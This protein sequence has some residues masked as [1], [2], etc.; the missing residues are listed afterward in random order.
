MELTLSSIVV[1]VVFC[2][3]FYTPSSSA[4]EDAAVGDRPLVR[5]TRATI[6]GERNSIQHRQLGDNFHR[7]VAVFKNIPFAE[8]PIGDLRYAEPVPK[9]LDGEFDATGDCLLCLQAKNPIMFDD[10]EPLNFSEDCLYL[11]V[12]VPEPKPKAAAVMVWIHGGGYHFGTKN[13]QKS[14]AMALV[15]VEDVIVVSINYRLGILGF[16]ST[17]DGAIPG[18]LGLLDQRLGLLWVK[19]NIAAFGG[20]PDRVTIFGESA[21]S[22]SVNCHLL[23]SMSAGLFSGA[24]MQSGAMSPTW[25]FKT[26]KEN[27]ELTFAFGKAM[28]CE[29][30][31]STELLTCLRGITEED[32]NALHET[33]TT[34]VFYMVAPVADGHFL[35]LDPM[36]AQEEGSFNPSNVIIGSL[37][38]EGNI[39]AVPFITGLKGYEKVPVNRTSFDT[40]ISLFTRMADPL[41]L[42][43]IKLAYLSAEQLT[44]GDPEENLIDPMAQFFG[45]QMFLCPTFSTAQQLAAAG[46]QVYTYLMTHSPAYSIWGSKYTWLEDTHGEDVPYV[47]GSA[48]LAQ[49][50]EDEDEDWMLQGRLADDEVVIARRIMKYWANFAKTGN[51]NLGTNEGD[52]EPDQQFPS[53]P[54]FTSETKTYKD[55]SRNMENLSGTTPNARECYF[56]EHLLPKLIE[57][58]AEMERL[59]SLVEEKVS[60]DSERS[61]EDPDTCPEE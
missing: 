27:A 6:R 43:L 57:N 31:S 22:S 50:G 53:W 23:S 37:G 5:T 52:Q 17:E 2:I 1:M 60:K 34:M 24:I 25:T 45:D 55:L 47:F 9:T 32:I 8:P 39:F 46:I 19:E 28:G 29:T 58:A 18:N 54:T 61:C 30:N 16:L 44:S 59:K 14:N 15:A 13:F 40:F 20:D 33:G 11:D 7:S 36:Q 42:D 41:A 35:P 21:G 49:D 3:G 10:S 48:F 12:L 26:Q 38:H 56:V 51:P 4:V